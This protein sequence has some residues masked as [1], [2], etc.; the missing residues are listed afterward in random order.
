MEGR[1]AGVSGLGGF[2]RSKEGDQALLG[3]RERAFE[4]FEPA[5]DDFSL[6]EMKHRAERP[7]LCI[8]LVGQSR[9]DLPAHRG[10]RLAA[11]TR[12]RPPAPCVCTHSSAV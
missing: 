4:R 9:G 5:C 2:A 12:R 1:S 7:Q 11:R 6:R 10:A 8:G 3:R